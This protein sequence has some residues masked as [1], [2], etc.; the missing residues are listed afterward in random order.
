M[1]STVSNCRFVLTVALLCAGVSGCAL[2]G[3][4]D[5]SQ[6]PDAAPVVAALQ[7][8]GFRD[9]VFQVPLGTRGSRA[10]VEVLKSQ[11]EASRRQQQMQRLSSESSV[12]SVCNVVVASADAQ[13][14]GDQLSGSSAAADAA[15][16]AGDTRKPGTSPGDKGK[17]ETGAGKGR[18]SSA[19]PKERAS[20]GRMA[21]A[22]KKECGSGSAAKSAALGPREVV[23]AL[24]GES[25]SQ[26]EV[27]AQLNGRTAGMQV[28]ATVLGSEEDADALYRRRAQRAPQGTFRADVACSTLV[29][30][31]AFGSGPELAHIEK[32]YDRAMAAI[33]DA[34]S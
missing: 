2:P 8:A 33:R 34:C 25:P 13:A 30:R 5:G 24:A 19:A 15:G 28:T 11:E 16:D 1:S 31:L 6:G 29:E 26:V 27:I 23:R 9:L 3:D 10:R 32:R 7:E 4:R 20:L 18:G 14:V 17:R 12:K 22:L 21:T